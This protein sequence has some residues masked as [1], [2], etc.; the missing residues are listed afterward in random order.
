MKL[1][2]TIQWQISNSRAHVEFPFESSTRYDLEGLR[3]RQGV[4]YSG[5]VVFQRAEPDRKWVGSKKANRHSYSVGKWRGRFVW[6]CV[7]F[8]I[9]SVFR[10]MM[11]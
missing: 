7:S 11:E 2:C 9:R 3:V 10:L 6:P 8:Y 4:E 5:A 1:Y